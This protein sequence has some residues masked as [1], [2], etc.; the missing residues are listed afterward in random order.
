MHLGDPEAS[1][2]YA[3]LC[4]EAAQHS[5]DV[6]REAEAHYALCLIFGLWDAEKPMHHIEKSIELSE[7]TGDRYWLSQGYILGGLM[8]ARQAKIAQAI[9]YTEKALYVAQELNNRHAIAGASVN[10]GAFARSEGDWERAEKLLYNGLRL[11]QEMGYAPE[12]LISIQVR[13]SELYLLQGDIE[14][15]DDYLQLAE[16]SLYDVEYPAAISRY[17]SQKSMM[18]EYQGLYEEAYRL[19][20]KATSYIQTNMNWSIVHYA[21][22]RLAW[23]Q[24]CINKYDEAES[25]LITVTRQELLSNRSWNMIRNVALLSLFVAHTGDFQRAAIMISLV[26]HHQIQSAW[27]QNHPKL[28]ELRQALRDSLGESTYEQARQSAKDADVRAILRDYL[29]DYDPNYSGD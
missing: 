25:Y 12:S 7:S 15:A 27:L 6:W 26:D 3:H 24:C 14:S 9:A 4:L 10:L 17:Y 21:T 1:L 18:A 22:Q 13:L 29:R 28:A 23:S 19:A 8:L 5:G 11:Q 16:K 20:S 2:D